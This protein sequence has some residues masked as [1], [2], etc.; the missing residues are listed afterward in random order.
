MSWCGERST[1]ASKCLR[2]RERESGSSSKVP[3]TFPSSHTLSPSQVSQTTSWSPAIQ[4]L[5]PPISTPVES[6]AGDG[7]DSVLIR[8]SSLAALPRQHHRQRRRAPVHKLDHS[9]THLSTHSHPLEMAMQALRE[10]AK[11]LRIGMIAGDGIGRLV[12]PVRPLHTLQFPR[13]NRRSLFPEVCRPLS[14]FSNRF[15]VSPSLLSSTS[16]PVSSTSRRPA[17]LFPARPSRPSVASA[18]LP[19]SVP[20]PPLRTR[21]PATLPPSSH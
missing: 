10:S 15:P 13:T 3:I 12:I 18:P 19:C 7:F 11:T 6:D 1:A 4:L 14:A 8:V 9:L 17:L 5:N 16:T 21:S 2:E 20:F